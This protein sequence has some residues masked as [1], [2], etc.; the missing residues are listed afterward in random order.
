MPSLAELELNRQLYKT[1]PQTVETLD[2]GT[3]A[4][5]LPAPPSNAIASGNSVQDV[6]TNAEQIN[7]E[8]IAPGT[9]PPEVLDIANFGWTQ[10]CIFSTVDND[11]VQWGSGTFLSA[12]G[13]SYAISAGNTGNMAAGT[14]IYLD[15]TVSETVYQVT[16]TQSDVVGLGKVLIAFCQNGSAGATFNLVQASRITVDNILANT[17]SAQKMNVGQLSAISAD[18]GSITAGT[19]TGATI[20]TAT[21]GKRLRMQG[22]P[23]NEYQFL[24][25]NTVIGSLNIDEDGTGGYFAQILIDS[26]GPV[27]SLLEVGYGI[28]ASSEVPYFLA[29]FITTSG[30]AAVGS[31]SFYGGPDSLQ[32][33]GLE[34]SGGG[35]AVWVFNCDI[36]GPVLFLGDVEVEGVT[37]LDDTSIVGTLTYKT[38]PMPRVFHG[39]VNDDGSEGTPFPSGW[40]ST[41]NSTGIYTVTH[42]LSSTDYSV[43][44]VPVASTVKDITISSRGSD[45]FVVRISN[46]SDTLE[47]N[48][49]MFILCRTA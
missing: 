40:S 31:A 32:T 29:P 22:S 12:N 20:Q 23:Q 16:T 49:F 1:Q 17:I 36:D 24:D 44:A 13:A 21:T 47:N 26:L 4:A 48:D 43:V 7:G 6:N 19:V 2:A 45:T 14:Y 37:T 39:F 35:D 27:A 38:T 9:I 46:L 30:R 42:D 28:G 5:N 11:T 25:G 33:A 18:L 8:V 15:I 3:V 34:W 41:N 10:T